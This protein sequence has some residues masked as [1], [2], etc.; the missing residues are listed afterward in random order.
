VTASGD[1]TDRETV[2][3]KLNSL[4]E[5]TGT[6]Y[7]EWEVQTGQVRLSPTWAQIV[8][9]E[10]EELEPVSFQT[11]LDL[12]HPEDLR[13][14]EEQLNLHFEGASAF[15][16][17]ESR[18]RHKNGNWIWVLDR[19]KVVERSADGT[20][21]RMIGTHTDITR[22]KSVEEQLTRQTSLLRSLLNSIPDLV[23]FK[24]TE[25]VYLG[26]N[27]RFGEWVGLA[28]EQVIGR[29][30][31][32]LFDEKTAA[33]FHELDQKVLAGGSPQEKEEWATYPDGRKVLLSTLKAPLNLEGNPIGM[34]G[35]SRDVTERNAD[36]HELEMR[37]S[38]LQAI[39]ENLP[40]LIWM[41]DKQSRFLATNR[42]LVASCGQAP[43]A[44]EGKSDYDIWPGDLAD[45]YRRDDQI[46]MKSG[47]PMVIEEE[48]ALPEGRRWHETFKM[49][50]KSPE[51]NI[52]GTVGYAHDITER[53]ATQKKI[54]RLLTIQTELTRL[55]TAFVSVPLSEADNLIQ[56]ALQGMGLLVDACRAYVFRHDLENGIMSNTHE[57]CAEGISS[58]IDNL[59]NVPRDAFPEW[60]EKHDRGEEVFIPDVQDL[61]PG[62]MLREV[63][64]PQNI[65]SLL[66]IPLMNG[67]EC[68]GFVGFDAVRAKRTWQRDDGHVLRLLAEMLSN[69]EVKRQAETARIK[70]TR[71]QRDMIQ[72]MSVMQ[73]KLL[74]AKEAAEAGA[75]AKSMFVA[76][77]SHEIRTPLNVIL[78]HAQ[79]L[80]R[81]LDDAR[82]RKSL[83]PILVSG[84]HL[85]SLI[86]DILVTVHADA[87]EVRLVTGSVDF[88]QLLEDI[89]TLCDE[90]QSDDVRLIFELAADLPRNIR[91]D[92]GK[93]R[94]ILINLI[95][96]ARKFTAA[97]SVEVRSSLKR[98]QGDEVELVVDVTDTGCGIPEAD[99]KRIFDIFEQSGHSGKGIRGAGLGLPLS[100]RYAQA[101]GGDVLL[102]RSK[103]CEGSSFRFIF[104]AFCEEPADVAPKNTRL[105]VKR[106]LG[107]SLRVM[108]V[109]DDKGSRNMLRDLLTE[110]GFEV[111]EASSGSHLLNQLGEDNLPAVLL[112]DQKMPGKTGL[113][114][115]KAL[116]SRPETRDLPIILVTAL[117]AP[118]PEEGW[119]GVDGFVPKPVEINR[120]LREIS[121]LTGAEL[122]V[123]PPAGHPS[124]Q[125]AVLLD[126][127]KV[128]RDKRQALL[129][130]VRQGRMD[131]ME[132]ALSQIHNQHPDIARGL[133]GLVTSFAYPQLIRKLT[134]SL[135]G[136]KDDIANA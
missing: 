32:D 44:L 97:G 110:A 125:K 80:E 134:E 120:L 8:G 57:W 115:A 20:P 35:I 84:E 105:Y 28:P 69:L 46:V 92:I 30:D 106:D 68:I 41:K 111:S 53:K 130:A 58:E 128:D 12:A 47:E 136:E 72:E 33:A 99:Q 48:M 85:L 135:K 19:G 88:Y 65:R 95:G 61:E 98:R 66:A 39:I 121:R 15:Y 37:E 131:R 51:G 81:T 102:L 62:S 116:R 21:L 71:R 7:W 90:N 6:G 78:G 124:G 89:Q 132:K 36:K 83:R 52:L 23:F 56:E 49:P 103:P 109:D 76:N 108:V 96:N 70:Y 79:L 34:L 5:A 123:L 59:Q 74:Q 29:K 67:R 119:Q 14:S 117:D 4:L 16:E 22:I 113:E 112:M 77:M 50:V 38:Y 94:Q 60:M 126:L 122:S 64:E 40:G 54:E 100:R 24:D 133:Q 18:M 104:K 31:S 129:E 9:Y 42:A 91:T 10:L 93:L 13:T 86:N 25:G 87:R 26:Y 114:T 101:M 1:S 127:A 82:A 43:A 27:P 63:L 17:C 107:N 118:D 75:R 45:L 11:W 2:S 3:P 55:A 73:E